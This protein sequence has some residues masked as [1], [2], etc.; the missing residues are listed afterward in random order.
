M[1]KLM[2]L[3]T[4]WVFTFPLLA[5][6]VITISGTVND[7]TGAPIVNHPVYIQ[8]DS[9][10]GF[11]YFNV[12]Y[13]NPNGFY[14][15]QMPY[16]PSTTPGIVTI[17]TYDCFQNQIAY[18]HT[19]TNIVTTINQ[20][21]VIC[22][23]NTGCHAE[24]SYFQ[25]TPLGVQFTDA[26][27][28][29]N[30]G[31]FWDFGD[32]TTSNLLNPFHYFPAPGVYP[33][34]LTIGAAGTTCWDVE[35]KMVQVVGDSIPGNCIA[36]F[37]TIQDP[38]NPFLVQFVNQSMGNIQTY[39][40]DF[41]DN[42]VITIN[43]PQNPNVTHQYLPGY[44]TACLTVI[45][46]DTLCN[47]A[48]CTPVII[49]STNSTC[50]AAFTYMSSS[51]N[52]QVVYFFDQSITPTPVSW[53]WDFGDGTYSTEQ[54]PVH[55]FPISTTYAPY[56]VCL[57]ITSA[58]STCYDMTCQL[59]YVGVNYGCVAEFIA[60]PIPGTINTI[61][62]DDM[63]LGDIDTWTWEFGDGTSQTIT[64][65]QNPDVTHYYQSSGTYTACLYIQ[66]AD[67]CYSSLCETII[68][69][70]SIP[71]C[72]AYFNYT[73]DPTN[74]ALVHFYDQS[75]GN[76]TDYFW[77]FGDG[78]TSTEQNPSHLF[79]ILPGPYATYSVC[80]TIM[81]PNLNCYDT[82]CKIVIISQN[83]S[84][85]ADFTATQ[86]LPSPS[87][88]YHVFFDDISAGNIQ[89]WTWDFGDGNIE[90]INYPDNPD[91]YHAYFV[92]GFYNVC[93]NIQGADSCYDYKCVTIAVGDSLPGC[94]AQF[95]YY[96]ISSNTGNSIQF[97]D[98]STGSPTQWFWN[99]GD[100][101]SS[102]QQNPVHTFGAPGI[103]YVCLTIGGPSCQ[104]VWC[105]E[106][107][108]G[109]T[110]NCVN[111]FTYANI[112]LSVNF[113]GYMVTGVN[114]L[115]VWDFGDNN[116]G[117]GE[118]IIHT[119]NAPGIY[120]VTLTTTT[121][122][123]GVICTYSSSQMI[124]VG[125]STSWNQLYGQVF[126]GNF[127]L[128]QGMVMLFSIDTVNTFVPFVDV[129]MLDSVGVYYFPM[130]PQ[131]SYVIYAIPFIY[132]FLPTY[133]GNVLYWQDAT[134]IT[135]GTPN[136]PYNI[137]LIEGDNYS[138]GNG[139]ITGQVTQGDISS[140]L[141]DK[142]T[143]LLKDEQGNVILFE[144]VDELGNFN[145][146]QLAYGTYYLYAELAGCASQSIKVVISEAT[147]TATVNLTLSGNSILGRDD[148][149]LTV[150]A[151]VVYPNPMKDVARLSLTLSQAATIQI[152]IV[153]MAGQ[154]VIY[155]E[156]NL[157]AGQT[158]ISIPVSQLNSGVYA[159]RVFTHEGLLL[160]RKLVK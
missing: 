84:C 83:Q 41:G 69:G 47:S 85:N 135:L 8:S 129:A 2:L 159:L 3:M 10:N 12:V 138:S 7:S 54:N 46:F 130:V 40:W 118:N 87:L 31:R 63:S 102:N 49:D 38:M 92:P 121:T 55:T 152:E 35:T 67:S 107:E 111:Y 53:F 23:N 58:D 66:G 52:N 156:E 98:L 95:S 108:V 125:D 116:C 86:I 36:S 80:L 14:D 136:N 124:T 70:D 11:Y 97:L 149:K 91:V 74:A 22:S 157:S 57:T 155:R 44:Y 48:Y 158:V 140:S 146:P 1:K 126:A 51:S 137:N 131:G 141:I 64:Y 65:P 114:A 27:I 26:S 15:D 34:S 148:Q 93:L 62:F 105:A 43:Y 75:L 96:P 145:F 4:L 119:Y 20:N 144:Q 134:V 115:Y 122:D 88:S 82:F 61:Q 112:G 103:Y 94:Q 24:Y 17:Y 153:N 77:D 160:T 100:G 39:I 16:Y 154:Q 37:Y 9:A 13:T 132:G 6:N 151:G 76:P 78:T 21:F 42:N 30:S 123:P 60:S 101:T 106:V 99:F 109:P 79:N 143:I 5:Q 28:G 18:M 71:G 110:M 50:N 29:V 32:G 56:N 147:P 68:V 120:F 72:Q 90:V 33:V 139:N 113:Q 59:I 133:Y 104:S 150:E 81:S 89:T 25:S 19:F 128:S 117:V 45:G 142:V 73:F 127:P